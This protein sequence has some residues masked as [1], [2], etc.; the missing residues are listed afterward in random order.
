MTETLEFREIQIEF[1]N[2]FVEFHIN[3][4]TRDT[5][6]ILMM[7]PLN[8]AYEYIGVDRVVE[9]KSFM[10][11]FSEKY[12]DGMNYLQTQELINKLL[13]TNISE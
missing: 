1:C 7:P 4:E 12:K 10:N 6:Y 3:K 11:E 5:S 2:Q 13:D 9:I 8:E